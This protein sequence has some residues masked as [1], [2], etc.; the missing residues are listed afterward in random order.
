MLPKYDQLIDFSFFEETTLVRLCALL[1]SQAPLFPL[2]LV[3]KKSGGGHD[4][5]PMMKEVHIT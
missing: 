5:K 4:V 2:T 3:L 1:S